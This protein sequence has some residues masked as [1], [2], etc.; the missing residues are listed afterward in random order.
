M[1]RIKES[2]DSLPVAACFF[3]A[4]G[5]VRLINHRMLTIG[6]QLRRGG[7]QT[8]T[9]LQSALQSPPD[10]IRCLNP[11]LQIFRFPDGTALRFVQE[12]I[13]TRAGISYTQVTAGD[14]TERIH[15][16]NQLKEEN[17]KLTQANERLRM[18]FRQ[19]PDIIR[20]EEI[21]AMKLRVHDNIGHSI[22][23]ARR[24]LL[25]QPSLEEIRA[26]AALWEQSITVLYR[27]NQMTVP[28]EPMETAIRRAEEMG[29]RVLTE[30]TQP[31]TQ[32]QRHLTALAIRECAA[33]C[34]RHAGGTELYVR[35]CPGPGGTEVILC[36]NGTPPR[37]EI[38]EGGGLSMLRLRVETAGGRMEIRSSPSFRLRLTLPEK[39]ESDHACGNC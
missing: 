14:V 25:R 15:R 12:P 23:A 2:F 32:G 18:L 22:L 5:V 3:D 17:E 20:Q 38:T 37:G 39:E 21:L 6:N 26:C 34:A 28:P 4:S 31:Q 36:N 24:T 30:G 10:A 13:T 29:V 16:Q 33:N 27:S 1:D 8:L 7:I 35:F 19:M 11:E 9:E